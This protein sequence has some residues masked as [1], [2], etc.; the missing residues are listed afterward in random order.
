MV[1]FQSKRNMPKI[2]KKPANQPLSTKKARKTPGSSNP[3]AYKECLESIREDDVLSSN[4]ILN[5]ECRNHYR[6]RPSVHVTD[7]QSVNDKVFHMFGEM[8]GQDVAFMQQWVRCFVLTHR[9]FVYKV[10]CKDLS[11]HSLKLQEWAK[12]LNKGCKVDTLA[13]FLLCIATDAHCFVHTRSGYWTTLADTPQSHTEYIQRCNLHLS[14][15]G[16]GIYVQHEI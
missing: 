7:E 11:E 4:E 12:D 3:W 14:Y 2:K 10:A 5:L 1:I 16:K 8:L 13:L 6:I 9:K 15:V